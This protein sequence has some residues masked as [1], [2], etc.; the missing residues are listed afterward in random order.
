MDGDEFRAVRKC[1]FHLDFADDL[2]HPFHHGVERKNRRP[3][4]MISATDLPSRMSSR[5]SEVIS[6]TASG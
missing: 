6:A 1:A 5:I 3:Y 4:A 2:A